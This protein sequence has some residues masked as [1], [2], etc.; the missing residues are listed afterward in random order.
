MIRISGSVI[1]C[2]QRFG[3]GA[4]QAMRRNLVSASTRA[5]MNLK[6]F[7]PLA[8][9]LPLLASF[10][11]FAAGKPAPL[12]PVHDRLKGKARKLCGS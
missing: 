2:E 3:F 12:T 4:L 11:L 6:T 5:D 10:S 7:R 8:K 1:L 9:S